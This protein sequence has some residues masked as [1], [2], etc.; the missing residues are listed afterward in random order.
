MYTIP[1]DF[2]AAAKHGKAHRI[3]KESKDLRTSEKCPCCHYKLDQ[4]TY[5]MCVNSIKLKSFGVGIPLFFQFVRFN[6]IFFFA[7]FAFTGAYAFV[8][9]FTLTPLYDNSSST[10]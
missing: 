10:G 4:K 1:P 9:S 2:K 8:L 6:M 7:M 5:S 3:V